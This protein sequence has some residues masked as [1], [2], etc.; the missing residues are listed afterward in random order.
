M[1][2]TVVWFNLPDT[3][4][5]QAKCSFSIYCG[6]KYFKW[7]NILVDKR[8][9]EL[10]K[11]KAEQLRRSGNETVAKKALAAATEISHDLVCDFV[12]ASLNFS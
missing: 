8:A 12:Q 1:I 10:Q 11:E 3:P 9:T 4:N 5:F 2:L 6:R 7:M